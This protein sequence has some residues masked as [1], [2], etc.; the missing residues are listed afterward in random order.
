[1]E[2]LKYIRGEAN[3]LKPGTVGMGQ[4]EVAKKLVAENPELLLPMNQGKLWNEMK[5]IYNGPYTVTLSD[6]D[7][8]FARILATEEDELPSA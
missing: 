2:L 3:N 4:A 7:M 5:S 1:M 8:A 6:Q